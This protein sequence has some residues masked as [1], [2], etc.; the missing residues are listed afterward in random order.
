[1]ILY[2]VTT[3]VLPHIHDEWL[4]WLQTSHVID[5]MKTG[6]FKGYKMCK[7]DKVEEDDDAITYVFQYTAASRANLEAYFN[8]HAVKLR[9]DA[10]KKF[11]NNFI[12]FRT[13]MELV[14]EG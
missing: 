14:Q 2:N 7:L 6:Y 12:A 11:G 4:H 8:N 3:K 1:M 9:E 5:V 13:V 10:V